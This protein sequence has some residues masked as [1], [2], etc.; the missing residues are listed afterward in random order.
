MF[1]TSFHI[2]VGAE[3]R[4]KGK[5]GPCLTQCDPVQSCD[6]SSHDCTSAKALHLCTN[7]VGKQ[8]QPGVQWPELQLVIN[9]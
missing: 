2:G 9:Q 6:M 4:K 1:H 8:H 5:P 7:N 3:E